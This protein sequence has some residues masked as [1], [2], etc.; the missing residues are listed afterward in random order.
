MAELERPP[1]AAELVLH[2]RAAM[3]MSVPAASNY[4]MHERSDQA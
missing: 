4:A 2:S 1:E 3:P